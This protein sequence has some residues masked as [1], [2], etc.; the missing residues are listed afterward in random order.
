M[1]NRGCW[2]PASSSSDD[3]LARQVFAP[4]E[5]VDGHELTMRHDEELPTEPG[6]PTMICTPERW[7]DCEALQLPTSLTQQ[8]L[9]LQVHVQALHT[10]VGL[11]SEQ[12][13]ELESKPDVDGQVQTIRD[14]VTM[15]VEQVHYLESKPDEERRNI[16]S[17][18]NVLTQQVLK[19]EAKHE[20]RM[21]NMQAQMG[22]VLRF[23]EPA[24][25]KASDL[26]TLSFCQ[27]VVS[28]SSRIGRPSRFCSLSILAVFSLAS[29][30][31][32]LM[33]FTGDFPKELTDVLFASSHPTAVG[34]IA[35]EKPMTSLGEATIA[36][37]LAGLAGLTALYTEEPGRVEI[38]ATG[39]ALVDSGAWVQVG[40][41]V[42]V[43][44]PRP[45]RVW[46]PSPEEQRH[47]DALA[48]AGNHSG[49]TL[50]HMRHMVQKMLQHRAFAKLNAKTAQGFTALHI[51]S[52]LGYTDVV[53]M[54]ASSEHVEVNAKDTQGWTPLHIAAA[55]DHAGAA[56]V[57]VRQARTEVD[58]RDF[59]GGTALHHAAQRGH[60]A[61]VNA[62]LRDRHFTQVA[63]QN[64][65]NM[66]A[67]DVAEVFGH[68]AL[69]NMIRLYMEES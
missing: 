14:Q 11:I 47:L 56:K 2:Q 36:K 34:S 42:A 53:K 16:Q 48:R 9:S 26:E 1:P 13:T 19:I 66:T 55:F 8:L 29:A 52:Y 38:D 59:A 50:N 17:Q 37:G 41:K 30:A 22:E 40:P 24:K 31:T 6:T 46:T 49:L 67:L 28:C 57:L 63:A 64:N 35:A 44:S 69:A 10:Q 23:A 27:R 18:M 7:A 54:L 43:S 21:R 60:I 61:V 62:L 25:S 15:L 4:D 51:A 68:G 12:M 39:A 5:L 20:E 3:G 33:S 65:L 45:R 32:W 58:A